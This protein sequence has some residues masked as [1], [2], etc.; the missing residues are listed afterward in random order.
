MYFLNNLPTLDSEKLIPENV[1]RNNGRRGMDLEKI[2]V[3][4][5]LRSNC[6]MDFDK[7]HVLANNRRSLRLM[8]GHGKFDRDY[9]KALQM[10]KDT[11]G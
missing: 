2:L 1:A 7:L 5:M 4:G 11:G 6:N 8:L 3:L 9:C 10:I